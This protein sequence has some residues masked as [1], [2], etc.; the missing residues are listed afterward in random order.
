MALLL[1]RSTRADIVL[2]PTCPAQNPNWE[3]YGEAYDYGWTEVLEAI[4]IEPEAS[5]EVELI[6]FKVRYCW[7][8]SCWWF[9][10]SGDFHDVSHSGCI[11]L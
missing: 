6:E 11:T 3:G 2:V 5:G 10:D 1:A 4:N 8:F 9:D 7:E